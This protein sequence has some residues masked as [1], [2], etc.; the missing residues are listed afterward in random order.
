MAARRRLS[1]AF[2]RAWS[3]ARKSISTISATSATHAQPLEKNGS[4]GRRKGNTSYTV[5]YSGR[6]SMARSA[7]SMPV[8]TV[9]SGAV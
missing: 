4:S 5:A 3:T 7:L 8:T 6:A 2:L 9:P 1:A